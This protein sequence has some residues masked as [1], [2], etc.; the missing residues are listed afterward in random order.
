MISINVL[1]IKLNCSLN[2]SVCCNISD[3]GLWDLRRLWRLLYSGWPRLLHIQCSETKIC[4]PRHTTSVWLKKI[5]ATCSLSIQARLKCHIFKSST[6]F[7]TL[8]NALAYVRLWVSIRCHNIKPH[9]RQGRQI[10]LWHSCFP[11]FTIVIKN[12]R[13]FSFNTFNFILFSSLIWIEMMLS[14]RILQ[15]KKLVKTEASWFLSF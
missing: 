2:V 14:S 5:T 12:Y 7:C 15:M 10:P 3:E 8:A 9:A 4:C 11:F 1:L 13:L 6:E